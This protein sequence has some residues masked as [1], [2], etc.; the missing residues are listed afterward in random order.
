MSDNEEMMEIEL[1]PALAKLLDMIR[2]DQKKLLKDKAFGDPHQ[3]RQWVA[4][5]L[6]ERFSQIV[7]MLGVTMLDTHQL[8][9]S[10]ATQLQ[11]QRQWVAKHLR[12]L[13][14]EV[15]DGEPFGGVGTEQIDAFGQALYALGTYL[16]A[17]YPN[18]KNAQV[19]YNAVA[20]AF[21]RLIEQLMGDQSVEEDEDDADDEAAEGAAEGATEAAED[22][23][24][25][26][27]NGNES[28][29]GGE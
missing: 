1:P 6:M 23:P 24:G 19:K 9:V 21:N 3:L 26:D 29:G 10:N 14:A 12:S 22:E 13:G 8:A 25:A 28:E 17:T 5:T 7:E 15:S 11:R 27:D 20:D 16:Q 4:L 18:D 2:A